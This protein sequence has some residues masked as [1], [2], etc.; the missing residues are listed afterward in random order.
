VV[1]VRVLGLTGSHR[2]NGN[3]YLI[4]K[5][6]F[7]GLKAEAEI[8]QLAEANIQWCNACGLCRDTMQCVID[9]DVS[10]IFNKMEKAD[11]IVISTPRYLPIPSKLMALIERIG[12]LYHFASEANPNLKFP[13][14]GK[15]S[16]LILV[17]AFGGRQALEALKELAFQIIHCWRMKLVT[18]NSYPYL[19]VLAKGEEIG[20]ALEDKGAI[21]Q[22]RELINK[23]MK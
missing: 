23:L 16:G 21:K 17:S 20:E 8:I 2:K 1:K 7:K 14:E 4:L 10:V 6:A 15:P 9:D 5:E 13:L 3:S 19:G 11:A 22:A 12:S 18:I